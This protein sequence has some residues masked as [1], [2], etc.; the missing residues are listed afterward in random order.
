[1]NLY[2]N[3]ETHNIMNEKIFLNTKFVELFQKLVDDSYFFEEWLTGNY[4]LLSIFKMNEE[5]K[6]EILDIW[7]ENCYDALNEAL[8]S[9]DKNSIAEGWQKIK[10]D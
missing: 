3:W 2:V 7:H 1:M 6:Q 8:N 5:D 10:I 4:S 9:K